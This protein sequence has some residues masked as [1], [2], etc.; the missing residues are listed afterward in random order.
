MIDIQKEVEQA[1][2]EYSVDVANAVNEVLPDVGKEAAKKLRKTAPRRKKGGDYAKGWTSKYEQHRLEGTVIIY[3]KSK[4]YPL[5]HLLEYGHLTRNGKRRTKAIT[6][7]AP[8]EEWA[9]KEAT[10]KVIRRIKGI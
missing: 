9:V 2:K 6:H 3:G 5:A 10:E 7:I 1:L 8:V 4:T